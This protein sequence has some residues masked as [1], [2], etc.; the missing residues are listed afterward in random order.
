MSLLIAQIDHLYFVGLEK[1]VLTSV[2]YTLTLFKCSLIYPPHPR[3]C[4][5]CHYHRQ[6]FSMYYPLPSKSSPSKIN[7]SKSSI[8]L[9]CLPISLR[10]SNVVIISPFWKF[11]H[12]YFWRQKWEWF[13]LIARTSEASVLINLARTFNQVFIRS[14]YFLYFVVKKYTGHHS[15]LK[16]FWPKTAF[17][18]LEMFDV[19]IFI[20][21]FISKLCFRS[22]NSV[23]SLNFYFS[24]FYILALMALIFIS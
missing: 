19:V 24:F 16:I 9:K 3:D 17:T 21:V 13:S 4:T 18:F 14:F 6:F 23:T 1:K 5:N 15:L 12:L 10:T 7:H 2:S 22:L 20:L 8:A 11:E